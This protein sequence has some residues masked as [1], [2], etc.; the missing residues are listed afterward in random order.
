MELY[1][2]GSNAW[3]QLELDPSTP[4]DLNDIF[5]FTKIAAGDTIET[6]IARLV[7]TIVKVDGVYRVAGHLPDRSMAPKLA[8]VVVRAN[9]DSL[10]LEKADPFLTL[11]KN[12]NG[13]IEEESFLVTQP[14]KKLVGFDTGFA[15]L[16]QDGVVATMGDARFPA[17]LGRQVTEKEP[18][19]AFASVDDLVQLQ[20]PV[21]HISACGY[22]TAA[23][24]KM[25][26]V[27]IWGQHPPS[28]KKERPFLPD[29]FAFANCTD[30]AD[31]RDIED[32]A[33]GE[34]HAI[35][36]TSDAEVYV[37]GNNEN[38][39][40]GMPSI[41]S[42]RTWTRLE[43]YLPQ[44]SRIIGVAAGPH[45]SFLLVSNVDY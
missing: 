19:E 13:K 11:S 42:T 21:K 45:T 1:A 20:D 15:I 4:H 16:Y 33:L 38:G 31:G 32:F 14:I 26:S 6:P 39:Q 40:L 8:E 25:G 29:L 9:G 28:R 36:L 7:Y 18:A 37:T 22:A 27:Y 3:G 35:A 41:T 12:V 34:T 44:C 10:R 17:T 5:E 43:F 24:T 30:I 23:L 2:T